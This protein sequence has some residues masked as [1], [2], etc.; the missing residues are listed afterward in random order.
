MVSGGLTVELV[1]EFRKIIRT[2][3]EYVLVAYVTVDASGHMVYGEGPIKLVNT[4]I[5]YRNC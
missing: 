3:S 1:V 2:Q 5:R 4:P